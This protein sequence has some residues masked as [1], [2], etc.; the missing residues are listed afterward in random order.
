MWDCVNLGVFEHFCQRFLRVRGR[1]L[2]VG[3]RPLI[4]RSLGS[5]PGMDVPSDDFGRTATAGASPRASPLLPVLKNL[6]HDS[7]SDVSQTEVAA[8]MTVRQTCV[9]QSQT[10]EYRRL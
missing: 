8:L 3:R 4:Y 9:I 6:V 5:A 10:L 2:S 7:A 1:V